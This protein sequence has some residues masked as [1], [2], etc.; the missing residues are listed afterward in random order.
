MS[1]ILYRIEI[2]F[3]YMLSLLPLRILYLLSDIVYFIVYIIIGYRKKVV[4]TNL[5][6]SFPEKS[7]DEIK[8]IAKKYYSYFCDLIIEIIKNIT[9]SENAV[10]KHVRFRD[11]SIF[12]KFYDK[13]QSVIIVMGHFGNWEFG[14]ARF[15]IEK[16]HELVVIYHPLKNKYFDTLFYQMRTRFGNRLYSQN[17]VLRGMIKDREKLTATAFIADQTP[18]A[19]NAYWTNFL[20]QDTPVFTG[21]G[22]IAKKLN[23]PVIYVSMHQLKRGYYEILSELIVENPE[24]MSENEISELHTRSLEKDIKENPEFWIWSHRRWKHKR[25]EKN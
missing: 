24:K 3:I 21:I 25:I 9:I 5:Q 23:Y 12:Q 17:E 10:R 19:P 15:C 14:G 18:S 2:A 6:N 1:K 22:K 20:H 13:K 8:V 11:T 7:E 16:L 4:F